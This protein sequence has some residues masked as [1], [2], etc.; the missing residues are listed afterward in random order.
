MMSKA[1]FEQW[2]ADL[3]GG[4]YEQGKQQ[5][6][7]QEGCYCCLG[8][9]ADRIDPNGWTQ[10]HMDEW[11]WHGSIFDIGGAEYGGDGFANEPSPDVLREVGNLIGPHSYDLGSWH[12]V[13]TALNDNGA[14]FAQIAD[15]AEKHFPREGFQP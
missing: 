9:R 3:R 8:V 15:F 12:S 1:D 4:R 7:T 6:R 13:F 14:T 10:D 11:V 2:M 5:L